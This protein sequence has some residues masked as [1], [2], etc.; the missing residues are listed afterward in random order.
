MKPTPDKVPKK[1]PK[2]TLGN[3][4]KLGTDLDHFIMLKI[5]DFIYVV[6]LF[7]IK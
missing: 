6:K 5:N 7:R 1:N 2:H 4:C 3:V